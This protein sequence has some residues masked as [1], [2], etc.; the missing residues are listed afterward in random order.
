MDWFEKNE[1][2]GPNRVRFLLE[3]LRDLDNTLKNMGTR[4][5]VLLGNAKEA[6]RN[7]CKGW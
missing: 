2:L 3:T 1:K 7:F 4:L 6:I 5:F